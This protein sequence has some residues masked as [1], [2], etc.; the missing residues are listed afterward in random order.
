MYEVRGA[1][2]GVNDECWGGSEFL[3]WVVGFFADELE[4]WVC[5]EEAR[6]DHFLDGL[7]GFGDEVGGWAGLVDRS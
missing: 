1:V 4:G 2:D 7:V 6:G 3:A 5:S